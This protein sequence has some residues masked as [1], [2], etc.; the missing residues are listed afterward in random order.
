MN[1]IYKFW[2]NRSSN[3][4]L[5]PSTLTPNC[6]INE[7]TGGLYTTSA[8]KTTDYMAITPGAVYGMKDTQNNVIQL[9]YFAF[10]DSNKTFISPGYA[11]ISQVIAPANA[12]YARLSIPTIQDAKQWSFDIATNNYSVFISPWFHPVYK[13]DLAI[14]FEQESN[15]Q[16]FRRKLSGKLTFV[17]DEYDWI[18]GRAFDF[19]Y[20][21][22]IFISYDGGQSWAEYWNGTFWK[23]DCE[24]DADNRNVVV[25]PTVKDEYNAVLA[26]LEKEYD[27][28]QLAP[29][30]VPVKLD[31]RPMIQVYIPGQSVI[32]C[33][34]SG[35]WW[36]QECESVSD[37]NELQQTYYF[38]KSK[39]QRVVDVTTLGTP[40]IPEI[41]TGEPY[42][43]TDQ[44][45]IEYTNGA[46]KFVYYYYG[47]SGGS[48]VRWE[49]VR[50]SDNQIMWW[51]ALTN[52]F[53]PSIPNTVTLEPFPDSGAT[54]NVEI[55]I[56]DISVY[57]RLVCDVETI[58]QLTTY[59]IP[60][61]DIVPNN[62]NYRR[63]IGY[64][65]PDTIF[66]TL[67]LS[68]TP[69]QYGLYQPGQYYAPPTSLFIDEFYPVSRNA[70]GRMSVWFAFYAF[71]WLVEQSARKEYTLK[72][73]YP[74]DSIISVL[75]GQIA[76]GITHQGT[77]GYSQF[78]Y[79][80]S[81]PITGVQQRLFL[82]PKSNLISAGY[83][84][85]AQKAPITLKTITDMLR[86]CFRCYC[87]IEDNKFKIEHIQFFNNGGSYSGT[88]GIDIDLTQQKV[89]RNNKKWAFDTSK[90]SFD[91]PEM[92]AR[93]QFGWMD[94]VTQLFEG[95]PI[96]I[97]SKYVN[98]DNIEEINV[99]NITSDVDYILLNPDD[100]SKDGFVLLAA[101]STL[102]YGQM[103]F[104]QGGIYGNGSNAESN[105]RIRTH[106]YFVA[107]HN[108]VTI[109]L[110]SGFK[111]R[112]FHYSETNTFVDWFG[113]YSGTT[114]LNNFIPGHHY[115]FV[116]LY[117]DNTDITPANGINS[118]FTV[119]N[120]EFR[121]PYV[122]FDFDGTDHILQN[123]WVSFMFLQ[124]YYAY[125]MPARWYSING[126]QMYASG[127]KKLKT[128]TLKFPCLNDPN[129]LRLIKTNMGNG[130]IKKLSVNLSSRNANATLRYDTE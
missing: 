55:Y 34:L 51:K 48:T 60:D 103:D 37:E 17:R 111:C 107:Q 64:Y 9:P 49:I 91:K 3:N 33:F 110:A 99:S 71:D 36:E 25:K 1:P 44:G 46:Y 30:I 68:A 84:Q 121:L 8:Y 24:F 126:Q 39:T 96:D 89:T 130:M 23:T 13:D 65:F 32:A 97:I 117:A 83:D 100:I 4:L 127:I 94:D 106:G 10:Y 92:A 112:I 16:F 43:E 124:Q 98:P 66:F 12:V 70:W 27:L 87:Y 35:M 19:E 26:G 7:N 15:Q 59:D 102:Q 120:L 6:R 115:R 29:E 125:D 105:N 73:A 47:S 119:N 86:N 78:L 42:V 20:L 41:F 88:P 114:E 72:D 109:S 113:D 57:S 79:G 21:L 95:F 69:T 53:P 56:H 75:L 67:N 74:L 54:G 81:T 128:Q 31:K 2:L 28:I 18:S 76:P 122:N 104:E 52:Q 77:I 118:N 5:D 63:V 129:V 50:V 45:T 22:K 85:P 11:G 58:N 116:L 90:Y 62:R 14:D 82:T 123:A 61:N 40:I 80:A 101:T 93:Y 108:V 38:S